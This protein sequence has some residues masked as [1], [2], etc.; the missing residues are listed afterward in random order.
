[1]SARKVE[2][3]GNRIDELLI[4]VKK[5]VVLGGIFRWPQEP[6]LVSERIADTTAL[7]QLSDDLQQ[8]LSIKS[9]SEFNASGPSTVRIRRTQQAKH[10]EGYQITITPEGID[11]CAETDAGAYYAVQTLRDLLLIYGRQLPVCRINDWPDFDRRG[12]YHDCSRGKVPTIET[13]KQLVERLAHW[14]INELQLYIENVFTFSRHPAIGKGYSPFT[15][16]DILALQEHCKQHHVRLVG[17]LA[18]F[19]HLEKILSLP[20]YQHLGEMPGFRG[21]PGGTTLCPGDPGSIKLVGELYEEFVPLFESVDFNVCCDETWE[22]GQGRSRKRA[23]KYGTGKVYLDFLLKIHRLCDKH[24][25]R[26]NLWA[27][28]VLKYPEVIPKLPCD[29]I[30]LNWEY[31]SNGANVGR[32]KEIADSEIAFMVCPGTSSWLTHGSRLPNAMNNI[33]AFSRQGYR[34]HGQGLLNTDWG[35]CGHRNLLGVSL[36]GFAY[37][38]AQSWNPK[39][40]RDEMFTEIFCRSTF[41]QKNRKLA[42]AI[43]LL[44]SAYLTCGATMPNRSLLFDA[45]FEPMV[46]GKPP[47]WSAIDMMTN[48]GLKKV[49]IQLSSSTLFPAVPDTLPEFEKIALNELKLAAKMDVLSARRTLAIQSIRQGR[50]VEKHCLQKLAREMQACSDEFTRLWRLRNKPSRLRDNLRLFTKTQQQM[51]RFADKLV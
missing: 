14:K 38:A 17:S 31:E 30:L 42:H 29:I 45:L 47:K 33:K 26:M 51:L 23:K 24:G 2:N 4:P 8:H 50:S 16:D 3:T 6:V 36:H 20:D 39:A 34:H 25:K 19:G 28:I 32:T 35:D 44:G 27:D 10:L 11:L 7:G 48:T 13:L 22:L 40:V 12:V 5:T 49:I 9:R 37:G 15:P 41:R 21:Y 43:T 46:Y 18:S 1:M